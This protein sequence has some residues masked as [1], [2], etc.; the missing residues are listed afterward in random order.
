M[1]E[2]A[3]RLGVTTGTLTIGIDKLEKKGLVERRPHQQDRRSWLVGLTPKGR[4]VFEQHH[5]FH[6]DYTQEIAAGLSTS[7]VKTL[8]ELLGRVLN[9]M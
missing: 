4:E 8:S 1:K 9:N 2:L 5:R 6:L 7:E 3:K